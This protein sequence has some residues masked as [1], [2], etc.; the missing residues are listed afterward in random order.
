MIKSFRHKGLEEF[1]ETGSRR[2]IQAN[3]SSRLERI[4]DRL[5]ASTNLEDMRLP[6]YRLHPWKGHSDMW[7]VDVNGNWHVVFEF[8]D[9]YAFVVDYLDPH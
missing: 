9:S 8:R 1:Y 5:D 7:S 2:G 3:H 4:L 6:G